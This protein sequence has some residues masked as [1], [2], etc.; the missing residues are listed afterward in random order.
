MTSVGTPVAPASPKARSRCVCSSSNTVLGVA[1]RGF[2]PWSIFCASIK[3]LRFLRKSS[4]S[5]WPIAAAAA[6]GQNS[7]TLNCRAGAIAPCVFA[8]KFPLL[9]DAVFSA[10]FEPHLPADDH[11]ERMAS[12]HQILVGRDDPG[13]NPAV[14]G[15]DPGTGSVI[16]GPVDRQSHPRQ[17]F[18]NPTPHRGGVF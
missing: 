12:D 8:S 1:K 3:N 5:A 9:P 11:L 14:R 15:A 10:R 18:T 4:S 2:R 13:R 16:G 6:I 7:G 17:R